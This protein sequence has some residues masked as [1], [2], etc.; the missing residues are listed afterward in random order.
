MKAL[1]AFVALSTEA[2]GTLVALVWLFDT[3]AIASAGEV[4]RWGLA[5]AVLAVFFWAADLIRQVAEGDDDSDP[6]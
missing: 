6:V 1:S 5:L 3:R 2:M 4:I